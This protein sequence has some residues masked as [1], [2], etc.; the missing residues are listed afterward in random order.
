MS[1]ENVEVVRRQIA[2][3]LSKDFET[4]LAT[5]S[6]DVECD[7]TVRPEGHVYKGREG[8]VEAFRVWRRTWENWK[9]EV[10]EITDAGDRVLMALLESGRGKGSGVEVEQRT[11]FVYTLRDGMIVHVIV[12]L[13]EARARRAAGLL[14]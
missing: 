2:A 8:I 1:H 7:T 6:P 11:F 3:Y 5:Y 12:L 14:A 13:D 4:A 9:G 10:E